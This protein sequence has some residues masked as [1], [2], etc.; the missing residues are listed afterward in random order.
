MTS[1]SDTR[2]S[3]KDDKSI[4]KLADSIDMT[5]AMARAIYDSAI[6]F[7]FSPGEAMQFALATYVRFAGG[8]K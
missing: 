5:I 7:G 2:K 3:T 4:E 6:K 8:A 1:K